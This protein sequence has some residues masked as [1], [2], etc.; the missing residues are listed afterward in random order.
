MKKLLI[1][2]LWC[3]LCSLGM[4]ARTHDTVSSLRTQAGVLPM[5]EPW[6]RESLRIFEQQGYLQR[7]ADDITLTSPPVATVDQLWPQWEQEKAQWLANQDLQA[8]MVLLD[9][10]LRELPTVLL[11]KKLATQIIFPDS[12][13]ALVENIYKHNPMADYFNQALATR[14]AVYVEQRARQTP[15][16]PVRIVEIGAGTGATTAVVLA[17]LAQL[18]PAIQEYCYTDLSKAFLSHAERSYGPA[19]PFLTYRLLNI[20]T[21]LPAQGFEVGGFDLVVA[22][23]V[24]HATRNIR[25]TLRQAKGLLKPNGLIF[26]N[27]LTTHSLFNHLTFGLLEGWWL[28]EDAELRIPG[29]PGLLPQT[30]QHVL[31]AEGFRGV[32]FPCPDAM[33]LGQ[34]IILA[35]SDGVVRSAASPAAAPA[36]AASPAA[37]TPPADANG[38]QVETLLL[39]QLATALRIDKHRL[40]SDEPFSSYGLDSIIAVNLTRSI[41]Q[42]LGVD[43]EIT[44]MFEHNTVDALLEHIL[45]QHP[46]L[47]AP[48]AA[49]E[50]P[51]SSAAA[52]LPSAAVSL[53]KTLVRV[54]ADALRID[55]ARIDPEEPFSSYGLDSIIAVNVTRLI[56]QTLDIDLDITVMFEHGSLKQLCDFITLQHPRLAETR[57]SPEVPLHALPETQAAPSPATTPARTSAPQPTVAEEAPRAAAVRADN[58]ADENAFAIIGIHAQFPGAQDLKTFWQVIAEGRNCI[59][60]PPLHRQD[61]KRHANAGASGVA[62]KWGGFLNGVHEFDPLFFGIAPSEAEQM[63]PEQRLLLMSVWNAVED[64]GYTPKTLAA[65]PT[66]VFIATSPSEYQ[67][68]PA[69]AGEDRPPLLAAPS[70]SMIPNRI[71]YLLNLQGPSEFCETTCSSSLVAL[72]RAVQSIRLGECEQA[73]VGGVNLVLSPAGYAGMEA[74]NMLSPDGRV[75]PFQ[76]GAAG[77]VR[78]EGVASVLLKPLRR[79]LADHDFVYAVV[80]GTAVAHGGRGVSL[81][82]PNILGMKTAMQQAYR[83][84]GID[85][86]TVSY[87]EAHGMASVLADSAEIGAFKAALQTLASE[88]PR[89]LAGGGDAPAYI[90]TLKPCIGHAEVVSG[91]AALIKVVLAMRHQTIP[92]IAGFTQLHEAISVADSRLKMAVENLPWDRLT[93]PRGQALPRR[94]SINSYGIGGVNAH[95]VLEE[96]LP[97]GPQL[98]QQHEAEVSAQIIV[99][100]AKDLPSLLS[101]AEH[102]LAYLDGE[103]DLALADVAHTLQVGREPMACRWATV[104]PTR[105]ALEAALREFIRS[106][107]VGAGEPREAPRYFVGTTAQASPE[108]AEIFS[109]KIG[110]AVTAAF[111]AEQ[112]LEDIAHYW[113]KGAT[114]NWALVSQGRR[115]RKLPLPGYPFKPVSIGRDQELPA[116]N[117]RPDEVEHT[118]AGPATGQQDDPHAEDGPAAVLG[119]LASVLGLTAQEWDHDRPLSDYGL[120]SLLLIRV[121][122]QIRS[123]YPAF[124]AAWVQAHH[125]ARDVLA[126][127]ADLEAPHLAGGNVVRLGQTYPELIQLNARTQGQPVFWVHGALGSVETYQAIADRSERPF[128]ALQARGFMTSHEPLKGVEAMAAYYI[129]AM[130]SVQPQGPYDIGGFCLGGI[131]GYEMTRQLQLQQQGVNSLVMVDSPDNTAFKQSAGTANIPTKNAAL[132]VINMLLWPPGVSDLNQIMNRMI[133]QDEVDPKL[134]D[135]NFIDRLAELARQRGLAMSPDRIKAFIRQ[136]I[137]VQVAYQFN[138]FVIRPLPQ[139]DAAQCHYF[140]N[141]QGLFYGAMS[142]YFTTAHDTFSLDHI[143]YWQDWERELKSFNMV[144]IEAANHMTIL[145]EDHSLNTIAGACQN[146]YSIDKLQS[147]A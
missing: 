58:A 20:E 66:G 31:E 42:A 77:T 17:K 93:D 108:V 143:N 125:T 43:L 13:L 130:R 4:F 18:H 39:E 49:A 116:A 147:Y 64:A 123:R 28:Y 48:R 11:G 35:E 141:R 109:G 105:Q 25:H 15:A 91:M 83:R 86:R 27:E 120:N 102:L 81:T 79:A 54:L 51:R 119:I 19:N 90:G 110:D 97:V 6:L 106:S 101:R 103:P 65:A 12:S 133:H 88:A 122:H 145:F 1:D 5:Y 53:H 121:L 80:K 100:S 131:V 23:N 74:V 16:T 56:N 70:L 41:N 87:I 75:Q 114:I 104:V 89:P 14:V 96:Y 132:Q 68:P 92:A 124:Q 24:L 78:S 3:H 69:P 73:I 32:S 95:A 71:S 7:S 29:S 111:L 146:L 76:P 26:L 40:R 142:P 50:A 139:P 82:A 107:S 46:A 126:R 135:E 94:A 72:H 44:V 8:Q 144:D 129:D 57:P 140:R 2:I 30:W 37:A 59:G 22:A 67:P 36:P 113:V 38:R 10:T 45:R 63:S 47:A 61:W 134:E 34:Q 136:N 84:A 33:D 137:A 60:A 62:G 21:P 52:A 112:R 115:V 128:Y 99:L 85:P 9:Q 138:E 55:A 127:L 117:A 98:Q 118:L